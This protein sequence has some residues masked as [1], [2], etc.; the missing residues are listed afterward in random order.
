MRKLQAHGLTVE[1]IHASSEAIV[2]EVAPT[3]SAFGIEAI[4]S[5]LHMRV[6]LVFVTHSLCLRACGIIV[7]SCY[8]V[9]VLV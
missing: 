5:G 6:A 8:R 7:L 1:N 4:R 2:R 9:I 3:P